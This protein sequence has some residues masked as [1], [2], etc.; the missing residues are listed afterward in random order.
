M[1]CSQ[2]GTT[3]KILFFFLVLERELCAKKQIITGSHDVSLE[4]TQLSFCS[5]VGAHYQSWSLKCPA[6]QIGLMMNRRDEAG[7][8]HLR[9]SSAADVP[10]LCVRA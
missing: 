8:C 7:S 5:F 4:E 3:L 2:E 10:Q 9:T 1:Y 6:L